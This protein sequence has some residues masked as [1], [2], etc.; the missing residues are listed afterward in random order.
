MS[1]ARRGAGLKSVF[2]NYRKRVEHKRISIVEKRFRTNSRE[3]PVIQSNSNVRKQRFKEE[4]PLIAVD[5]EVLYDNNGQVI[6]PRWVR[7]QDPSPMIDYCAAWGYG[8]TECL[9][10]R[11]DAT[12][13][14][15]AGGVD[16]G[17]R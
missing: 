6:L 9:I 2:R 17:G 8:T 14:G 11:E 13:G 3:V 15:S 5:E 10:R 7:I 4:K 1:F 12:R 16:R